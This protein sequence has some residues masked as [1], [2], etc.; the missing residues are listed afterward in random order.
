MLPD[1]VMDA[2]AMHV[3]MPRIFDNDAHMGASRPPAGH[4]AVI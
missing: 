3:A 2:G 1:M 4:Q